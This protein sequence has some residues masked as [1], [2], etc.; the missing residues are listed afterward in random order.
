MANTQVEARNDYNLYQDTAEQKQP[1]QYHP[2]DESL[3][4]WESARQTSKTWSMG[5]D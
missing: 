1:L 4:E 3:S 5:Q 2:V